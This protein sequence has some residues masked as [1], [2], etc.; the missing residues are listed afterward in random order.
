MVDRDAA[1]LGLQ[2]FDS[3]YLIILPG[4]ID[5]RAA[6]NLVL[7]PHRAVLLLADGNTTW[8]GAGVVLLAMRV[9]SVPASLVGAT[10]YVCR[11]FAA[12]HLAWATVAAA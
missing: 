2:T 6:A 12:Q 9:A 1:S 4:R 8:T 5:E 7:P 11:V 3:P 10:D